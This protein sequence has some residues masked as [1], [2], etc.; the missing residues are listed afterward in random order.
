MRVD[1]GLFDGDELLDRGGIVIGAVK[2]TNTF[3]L[4]C[5][6]HQ[7]I[8]ESADVV[9]DNFAEGMGLKRVTLDMPVHESS[10]WESVELDKFTLAFWC[11]CDA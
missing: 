4:F 11:R 2:N 8:D 5:A 9:L 3:K 6:H 7:L 10:D 1:M